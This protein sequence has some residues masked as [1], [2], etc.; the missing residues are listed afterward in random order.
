MAVS[1]TGGRA[2]RMPGLCSKM[3]S[4]CWTR[5]PTALVYCCWSGNSCTS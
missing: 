1:G 3:E 5:A 4:I 2:T